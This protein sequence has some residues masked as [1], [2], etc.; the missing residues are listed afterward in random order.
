MNRQ[1]CKKCGSFTRVKPY[2]TD[3]ILPHFYYDKDFTE[4]THDPSVH[5]DIIICDRCGLKEKKSF[6][7]KCPNCDY[8]GE[9]K[10]S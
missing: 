6:R 10:S 4:H 3:S 7:K 1:N 2:K 5:T 8:G 9:I